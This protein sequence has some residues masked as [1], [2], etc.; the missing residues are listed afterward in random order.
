MGNLEGVCPG[1]CGESS[2]LIIH[3]SPL[4]VS[5]PHYVDSLFLFLFFFFHLSKPPPGLILLFYLVFY[6]FLA[7][8]F[9]LTMW[10]MLLTLDDYVPRYRDRV[11]FP[12]QCVS[13][14]TSAAP[15]RGVTGQL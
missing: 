10:V 3:D 14:S 6:C 15:R 7:G 4:S 11:P 1:L 8:M 12:G 2:Q 13:L 9:A 5:F